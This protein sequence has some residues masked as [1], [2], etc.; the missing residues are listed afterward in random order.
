MT[1]DSAALPERLLTTRAVVMLPECTVDQAIAPIEVLLQEGLD[2]V[3]LPPGSQLTP[4]AL[5]DI[6]G[7]RLFVGA[8]DLFTAEDAAWAVGQ[9]AGFALAMGDA[10][11]NQVLA[12]AGLPYAPPA[13]TPTEVASVWRG[14]APAVQ[15]V[16]ASAFSGA[17]AAQLAALVP[18]VRLIARDAESSHEV[19]RWLAAGAVACCLGPKLLGDSLTGGE[20]GG[21][22]S[23]ARAMSDALQGQI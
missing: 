17:Y 8:H 3:S 2:V 4:Q 13:L 6:F 16:P 10:Q 15:V 9:H 7:R 18:Q 20:L 11:V 5:R 1:A 23:R 21:L 14:G 22:R 12:G 19:K